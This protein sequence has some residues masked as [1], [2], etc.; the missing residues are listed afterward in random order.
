MARELLYHEYPTDQRGTYFRQFWDV[1]GV[2]GPGGAPIDP[3]KLRDIERIHRWKAA[4]SAWAPIPDASRAPRE[5]HLVFLIKGE[6]LRRYPDTLVYA[7][8]AKIEDGARTLGDRGALSGLRGPARSRHRVLRLRPAG[9]ARSRRPDPTKDQGWYFVLQEQPTEP[10]FGLDADDGRYA[11][12]PATWN[13]LNWAHLAADSGGAWRARLY[14]SRRR[15]AR[16]VARSCPGRTTRRSP[17]TPTAA[18]A[19]PAPTVGPCLH[20]AAAAV[21]RR[22]PRLRHAV[23]R[24]GP[25]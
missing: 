19:R 5:G 3:E 22:H 1:R 16:H 11:A 4:R 13:D 9:R 12:R 8:K 14:R 20:H 6:L 25:S 17:G 2:L 15:P 18:S 24:C 10:L 7:V 23:S 21:P